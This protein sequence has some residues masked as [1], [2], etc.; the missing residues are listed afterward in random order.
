MEITEPKRRRRKKA[1]SALTATL[2]IVEG[3]EVPI[4]REPVKRRKAATRKRKAAAPK[5]TVLDQPANGVFAGTPVRITA[6]G[7]AQVVVV[8]DQ[9]LAPDGDLILRIP[10]LF[11]E[12]SRLGGRVVSSGV[13]EITRNAIFLKFALDALRRPVDD[14]RSRLSISA[15]AP[16]TES[17]PKVAPTLLAPTRALPATFGDARVAL[18]E[19]EGT[20]MRVAH[21]KPLPLEGEHPFAVKTD[22]ADF[23]GSQAHVIS[24]ERLQDGGDVYVSTLQ[25][26]RQTVSFRCGIDELV[27][28]NLLQ[29]KDASIPEAPVIEADPQPLHHPRDLR[30][31]LV[32]IVRLQ[33]PPQEP[34]ARRW[35]PA[36]AAIAALLIVIAAVIGY[37]KRPDEHLERAQKMIEAYEDGLMPSERDY[38]L[39]VYTNALRE[40]SGVRPASVSSSDA[41]KLAE[42]IRRLIAKQHG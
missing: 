12:L 31:P 15:P 13:I 40:L 22:V 16:A 10:G 33:A 41:H 18:L 14:T 28:A 11:A 27:R 17:Q 2:P 5:H 26:T 4:P 37:V 42:H 36:A 32:P 24:W 34:S 29:E 39:P 30:P 9:P 1:V 21:S 38:S 7:E 20:T 25:I 8:H 6:I 35:Q 19:V 3:G 23:S